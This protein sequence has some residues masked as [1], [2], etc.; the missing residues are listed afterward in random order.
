MGWFITQ[1]SRAAWRVIESEIIKFSAIIV[2][3]LVY[4]WNSFESDRN[5]I[6]N[7][8]VSVIF[9]LRTFLESSRTKINRFEKRTRKNLVLFNG[10][11]KK[12]F[13]VKYFQTKKKI[14]EK[15]EE[16]RKIKIEVLKKIKSTGK[17]SPAIQCIFLR[18]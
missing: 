15:R 1:C 14:E 8:C 9:M 17:L 16:F 18:R 11:I 6:N 12:K 13:S 2:G 7:K 4:Q 3:L 10:R 5:F